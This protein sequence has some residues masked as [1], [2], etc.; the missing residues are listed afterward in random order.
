MD[1]IAIKLLPLRKLSLSDDFLCHPC[2]CS[3]RTNIAPEPR[4]RGVMHVR[5]W[6]CH[7]SS[8]WASDIH[9]Q[10]QYRYLLEWSGAARRSGVTAW[11]DR[12]SRRTPPSRPICRSVW[13]AV[14][15]CCPQR[16]WRPCRATPLLTR[17]W[18]S[19]SS[20]RCL[21]WVRPTW[22]CRPHATSWRPS[23]SEYTHNS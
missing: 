16:W 1:R 12:L 4:W 7:G 13:P 2:F 22:S 20:W 18:T 17:W 14:I 11:V 9:R 10:P 15:D 8:D 6:V 19:V 5:L 3:R 23:A 21:C